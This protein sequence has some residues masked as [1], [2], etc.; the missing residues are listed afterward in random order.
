M[1]GGRSDVVWVAAAVLRPCNYLCRVL[2]RNNSWL[3]KRV[4]P[5]VR[6]SQFQS[7]TVA[8]PAGCP[9]LVSRLLR[10]RAGFLT[11]DEARRKSKSPASRKSV[12]RLGHPVPRRITSAERI[13]SIT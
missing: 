1:L 4:A 8:T 10:D 7:V 11:S 5:P 3:F 6:C 2:F 12:G 9:V 13:Q